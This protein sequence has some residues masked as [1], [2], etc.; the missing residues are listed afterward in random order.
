MK[1]TLVN[2]PITSVERYGGRNMSDIGGHQAPLGLCYLA[3]FLEREGFE[4]DLIDAEAERLDNIAVIAR[5]REFGPR[6]VGMT[7]TT[8]A[9]HRAKS[10][11]CDIKAHD[12]GIPVMIGGPHVSANPL[13]TLSYA[14]FDYGVCREGEVTASEL[15]AAIESGGPVRDIPGLVHRE[16]GE[17]VCNRPR[18]YIKDLD[19]I[20]FPARHLLS[21]MRIYRPPLGCY[22]KTPVVN[23][24]TSRGCPYRCIFCDNNV[25]GRDIRYHSPEYVV[26]EVEHVVGRYGAKEIAFLDDTFTV[27]KNRV[28]RILELMG[29]RGIKINWSCMTRAN[30]MT[31]DLAVKMKKAGCWQ[32]AI[33]AESGNRAVLDLIKKGVTPDEVR[34]AAAHCREAGMY[35]KGFFMI[36]HPTDTADTIDQTIR[37]AKSAPFDDV[38]VTISTP[39]PGTEL[40]SIAPS[41]GRLSRR[42]W[43]EFS[44]FKAVFV[45]K[46]LDEKALYRE[47]RRFYIEFY[48]RAMVMLRQIMKIRGIS[49][50][51]R[52]ARNLVNIA[53]E[54]YREPAADGL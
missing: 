13:Q 50:L 44:Y 53:M 12:S 38:V 54:L 31:R 14:C 37:F 23:I 40:Y 5:I 22:L 48:L 42:D 26:A 49:E 16:G 9:F 8:V 21:D 7:S 19:S 29:R 30:S 43:S 28:E 45:P 24:I 46:D 4:V 33:G 2:P 10:L 41:Y 35:V 18:L 11:A 1:I 39:M 15:L 27:N 34:T 20:P 47:Q 6:A 32:V 3:A 25:F 51:F 36:G 17:A 52:Y